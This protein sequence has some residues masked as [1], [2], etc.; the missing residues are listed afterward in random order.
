MVVPISMHSCR[1]ITRAERSQLAAYVSQ[2][3]NAAV[4]LGPV[5]KVLDHRDVP[6]VMGLEGYVANA[7]GSFR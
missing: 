2:K 5:D 7:F 6:S 1:G 4:L 3:E